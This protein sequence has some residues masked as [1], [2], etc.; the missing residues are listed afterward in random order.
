MFTNDIIGSSRSEHGE[1]DNKSVRLFAE[2]I[3][4]VKE[5]PDAT[6]NLI[7]T[8]GESDSLSA[9]WR[10]TSKKPV[11]AMCLASL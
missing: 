10:A 9:S 4:A 7:A 6:R 2:G 11:N 8:G 1:I 5:L 3:P